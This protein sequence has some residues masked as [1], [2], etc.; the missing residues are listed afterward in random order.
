MKHTALICAALLTAVALNGQESADK[1]IFSVA[2]QGSSELF[3]HGRLEVSK[4]NRYLRFEDGTP[5]FWLGE[6]GWLLP[7]RLNRDQAAYYL[8]CCQRGG[9]NVVQ[10]QTINGV[11]AYNCYGESSMPCGYDFTKIDKAGITG[12]WDHL[13]YIVE[14]AEKKGIFVGMVCVWGGLVKSGQMNEEQMKEYGTFLAKRYKDSPNI[15]WII[16]G[17]IRGDV[18][19][20]EWEALARAIKAVDK[21]HLMTFHPFG[22]TTSALWFGNAEWLDFNMFQSGHRRYG[23]QKPDEQEGIIGANNEEDNWRYVDL[24]FEL[25]PNKPVVDG[26]PS[27]E[28][29]PQGLH[30]PAEPYWQAGDVRRYA[31]WS[32]FGGSF[33]HTYGNNSIMQFYTPGTGAAYGAKE[34]WYEAV[35]DEGFGQMKYLKRL[36]LRFPFFERVA[37]QS[38]IAADN[39]TRY[40]RLAATRGKDYLLVYNYQGRP[41]TIDL[42]KIAGAKKNVWIMNPADGSIVFVG[43]FDNGITTFYT[44]TD[45]GT[46]CDRVLIATDATKNYI[47]KE[48]KEI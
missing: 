21:N 12:Y 13:D 45:Y 4:E 44:S 35:N 23:Q 37:D 2:T 14:T 15:V 19:S 40:D 6:T 47:T 11:P 18:K 10:I 48:Q 7:E 34:Y 26:E 43:T 22:R 33:G 9:Y 46:G 32:V 30:D 1:S 27:Y 3:T 36:M 28:G 29:I 5:F 42:G 39:G 20:A 8:D 16:G 31:Y 24:S 25:S 41:M 17:D 38:V